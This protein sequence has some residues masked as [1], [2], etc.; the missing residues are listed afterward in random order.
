MRGVSFKRGLGRGR[1]GLE[2]QTIPA[3]ELLLGALRCR[4][5]DNH[6]ALAERGHDQRDEQTA[7]LGGE[8]LWMT[9]SQ[10]GIAVG[11]SL[12]LTNRA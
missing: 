10:Q 7:G 1:E 6:R 11:S 2:L 9:P 8:R 12:A 3:P 5:R 4:V